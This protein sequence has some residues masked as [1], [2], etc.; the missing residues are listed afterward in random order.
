MRLGK[1][2]R[3]RNEKGAERERENPKQNFYFAD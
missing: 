3:K 1:W 2:R